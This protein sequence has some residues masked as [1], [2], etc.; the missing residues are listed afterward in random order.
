[1]VSIKSR[2]FADSQQVCDWINTF[3]IEQSRIV[4]ITHANNVYVVFYYEQKSKANN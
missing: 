3:R 1:M 2:P 4:A